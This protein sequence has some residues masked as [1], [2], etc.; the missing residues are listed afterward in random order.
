MRAV[1][2]KT[3]VLGAAVAAFFLAGCG[4]SSPTSPPAPPQDF[5]GVNPGT[6]PDS[7]DFQEMASAGVETM[8]GGLRWSSVQPRPGAY[9]WNVTD[10]TIGGLAAHGLGYLPILASTPSWVAGKPT[11]PPLASPR[12]KRA[13]ERFLE[14][15]VDRYGPDGSFWR[16]GPG[17]GPSP[18]HALCQCS[19]DPVPI[20]AWQVWNEPSLVNYFTANPAVPSYAE[21][22]RISHDA[23]KGED[24][25]AQ[26]VLAG[27]P[28][29]PTRSGLT[30]WQF[31][32]KLFDQP[33]V[34]GK[35]DV[36]ALHPY[37]RDVAELGL[38]IRKIRTVM[39]DN[40]DGAKPLWLTELGWGSAPPDQFELNKGV[41]GQKRL[42]NQSFTFLLR[43]HEKWHL[44]RVYWFEWRDPPASAHLPC[45]FC[46]SAGL[47]R[48]DRGRK[49]AYDAFTGFSLGASN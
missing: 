13:W 46:S 2:R 33:G 43:V 18:F 5:F 29:Y 28:G 26:V 14:A 41:Q 4:S 24:P 19:A 38:E 11:T 3:I 42:L 39:R 21:L 37:S 48:N 15:A 25:H 36:V 23:I 44:D 6:S 20:S 10:A 9:D 49:P 22:L 34:D 35:F 17:G 32:G 30:A 27:V 1:S 47:L 8:R 31:L 40:G 7:R 12:V 45:G 16:P